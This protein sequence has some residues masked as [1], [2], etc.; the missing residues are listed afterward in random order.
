[1]LIGVLV[2]VVVV[3]AAVAASAWCPPAVP[4]TPVFRQNTDIFYCGPQH[5]STDISEIRYPDM[6]IIRICSGN[7]RIYSAFNFIAFEVRRIC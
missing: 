3:K 6:N 1:M 5:L 4:G 7:V 2:V